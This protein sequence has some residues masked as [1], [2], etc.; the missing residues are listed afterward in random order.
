MSYKGYIMNKTWVLLSLPFNE[1][2][3][4]NS[5]TSDVGYASVQI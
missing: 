5:D 3:I 4:L 1:N 2:R